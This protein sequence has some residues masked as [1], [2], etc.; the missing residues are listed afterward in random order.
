MKLRESVAKKELPPEVRAKAEKEL[1]RLSAMPP[2]S[3]EV[4]IILTYLDWILNLP[5]LDE[6][7][8]N[9]DVRH[10]ADVLASD[11]YGLEKAKDRILGIHRRQANRG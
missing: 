6:S 11:H 2:M 7:E 9:M 1:G 5:W 3:P 8:D 4:G 10:A